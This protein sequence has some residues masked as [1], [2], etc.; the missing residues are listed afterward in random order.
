MMRM[1]SFTVALMVIA[2]T[3]AIRVDGHEFS[4][5]QEVKILRHLKRLNKPAVKSIKS[6]DGDVIDCVP[7]TN[8]PAFDH[9]L[10]KHHTMQVWFHFSMR[11]SFIPESDS[12]YINE[13][14]KTINQVWHKAGEC[15]DNTVPIRRT[16]KEDLLRPK[17]MKRF[18]RKPH[19]SIPRTTTFDPTKGHQ[20]A[21]M[22]ARNG[23]FYGTEVV[24]NLWKPYVQVPDEFSL[25]QTWIVSGSGSSLNTIEAGWQVYPEL[26]DDNRPRFFVYWTPVYTTTTQHQ[27]Q[28][29]YFSTIF[30]FLNNQNGKVQIDALFKTYAP[31]IHF[32][33]DEKYLPSSVNWFFSNGALLYKKGEESNPVPVEPNGSNLPQGEANDGLYW[34]R[35]VCAEYLKEVEEPAWLNYMRHW[36]PKIDYGREDEIKGV[37]KIVVG[38][39]LKSVFRS[40]VYPGI[41]GDKNLR[42][43][44]FWTADGYGKTGC[45]NIDCPGF[46]QTSNRITIGRAYKS[47]SKYEGV[48]HVLPILIWKDVDR[49]WLQVDKEVVGYWP[50]KIF[51]SLGKGATDIDWGGEI[52]ND[53]T[54]GKHT[55]TEMGSGHF[56]KE[57]F[58]K[59]SYF[60][61]LM[62]VDKS[63][64]LIE[65]QGLYSDVTNENCYS[66][67]KG[68]NGTAWGISFFYGGPGRNAKCP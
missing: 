28:S 35:V 55:S 54:G 3:I 13:E 64:T 24:I 17:S 33:K 47:V 53:K 63:N 7:I 45:Y 46:V 26:Y 48:Q 43:F 6:E 49:W 4:H 10:L 61:N 51:S 18:G 9:P 52:V 37:E 31:L 5:H 56:A 68:R 66:I 41:S 27:L 14:T 1:A 58:K 39:S 59:A 22:G 36:G 50:D 25:A 16:K 65:P 21:I 32:H 19:H 40:A 30:G 34:F 57:G 20:Y 29:H 44:V 15:P 38:E 42:L 23:K 62:I 11:P 67:K 60:K 2:A 8:Q 12:T